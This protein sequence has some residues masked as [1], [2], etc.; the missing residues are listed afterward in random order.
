MNLP[1]RCGG[2]ISES[3]NAQKRK[4]YTLNEFF[5]AVL[6]SGYENDYSYLSDGIG[7]KF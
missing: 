3:K 6:D 1:S 2:T 7:H 4:S 5:R